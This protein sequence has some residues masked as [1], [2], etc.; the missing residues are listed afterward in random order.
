MVCIVHPNYN[1]IIKY[2]TSKGINDI[3][4]NNWKEHLQ[5]K[6]LKEEI[7]KEIDDF[8]RKNGLK[9]FEIPKKIHLFK[10]EFSVENQVMT[11]TMKIRRHTAKKFFEKE[12]NDMYEL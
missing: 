5:D 9:G 3:D 7:I 11:P 12:I 4:K 10:D 6:D 2:F 8:G 1:D